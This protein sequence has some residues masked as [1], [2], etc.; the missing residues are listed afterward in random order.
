MGERPYTQLT[1]EELHARFVTQEAVVARA[2]AEYFELARE[3][4]R[5]VE[6]APVL[7]AMRVEKPQD[8]VRTARVLGDLP[9]L[10]KAFAAGEINRAHVRIAERALSKVRKVNSAAAD[11]AGLARIDSVFVSAARD[12][13]PRELQVVAKHLLATLDPDGG[14]TIDPRQLARRELLIWDDP[15]GMIG[16]KGLLDPATGRWFKAAIDRFAKPDPAAHPD[17][18]SLPTIRDA[19]TQGQRQADALQDVCRLALGSRRDPDRP[20]L[21]IHTRAD[22]NTSGLSQAWIGRLLCDAE[23]ALLTQGRTDEVLELGRTV[24]LATAAQRRALAG[25]DKT[26]VIPNCT[27]P[28]AWCDA[29]HVQWH[30]KGGP[31]NVSNLAMVCGRHHTE[32]HA[33]VWVLEMRDGIPWVQPPTWLDPLQRWRRNTYTHHREAA[34]QLAMDLSPPPEKTG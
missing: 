14:D 16:V 29:H 19:R 33:G 7:R 26:C 9:E 24:R 27:I 2:E 32:T 28:A 12:L 4:D 10:N 3:L 17:Q 5:R 6:L 23:V 22:A 34:E 8:V 13:A 1:N 30:S 31:T 21:V 15:T 11:G 25:R 18:E 20:H